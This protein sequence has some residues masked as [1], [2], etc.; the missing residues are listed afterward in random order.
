MEAEATRVDLTP[1]LSSREPGVDREGPL[2]RVQRWM[3]ERWLGDAE[4]GVSAVVMRWSV[5]NPSKHAEVELGSMGLS[6]PMNQDFSG[7]NLP[8]VA[9]HCSFVEAYAGGHM[10]YVQVTKAS[11]KGKV[12]L[13]VPQ[14]G[15]SFEAW[16]PLEMEDATERSFTFEGHHEG[17]PMAF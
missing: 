2:V 7:R 10:G 8:N 11:G 14:D 5:T 3:E 6:M 16:R 17:M 12:L 15:T 1:V 13:L 9:T 4:N